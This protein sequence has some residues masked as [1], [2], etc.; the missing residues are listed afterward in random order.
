MV[1]QLETHGRRI[2][3]VNDV[4]AALPLPS[5]RLSKIVQFPWTTLEM[6]IHERKLFN[7]DFFLFSHFSHDFVIYFYHFVALI[8][9]S[10]KI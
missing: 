5:V 3:C 7:P 6:E 4:S 8:A 1:R 9:A 2:G 10:G